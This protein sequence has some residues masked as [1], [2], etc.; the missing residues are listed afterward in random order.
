MTPR[1]WLVEPHEF[2]WDHQPGQTC[3]CGL[4]RNNRHHTIS[5]PAQQPAEQD[6]QM[7]L[8]IDG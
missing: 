5:R 1:K 8:D 7:R 2:E 3:K 4:P 6:R